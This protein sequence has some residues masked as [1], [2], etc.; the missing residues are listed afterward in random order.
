MSDP[1]DKPNIRRLMVVVH[2]R[3]QG[4][5][6]RFT[7][8]EIARNFEITGYVQNMMDGSVKILAEGDASELDRFM[9][10][11]RSSHIYRYVIREDLTWHEPAGDLEAF[12]IRYV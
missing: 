4:V 11:V 6:F 10:G 5:G 12:S 3:V 7:T 9:D 8:V 1:D 2:G